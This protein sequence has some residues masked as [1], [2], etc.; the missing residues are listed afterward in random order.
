MSISTEVQS[1]TILHD[2]ITQHLKP[3]YNRKVYRFNIELPLPRENKF[4]DWLSRQIF[5]I[6]MQET[7][8]TPSYILQVHTKPIN[9]D[10]KNKYFP[11]RQILRVFHYDSAFS[12]T[13]PWLSY[14][15]VTLPHFQIFH[16]KWRH[17]W[18]HQLS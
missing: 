7:N 3:M 6:E 18:C 5:S 13:F 11:K 17:F 2:E 4:P 14:N 1:N 15:S 16:R 8:K 9:A 10:K 12:P